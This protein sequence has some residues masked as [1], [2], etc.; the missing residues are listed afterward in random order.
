MGVEVGKPDLMRCR[1]HRPVLQEVLL[2]YA[3]GEEPELLER[4]S[5]IVLGKVLCCTSVV[6]AGACKAVGLVVS[7]VEGP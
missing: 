7:S 1:H 4:Y 6:R 3:R 5:Q 2:L